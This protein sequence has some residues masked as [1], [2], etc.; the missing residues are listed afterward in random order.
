MGHV[1]EVQLILKEVLRVKEEMH[2]FYQLNRTS[3]FEVAMKS[4]FQVTVDPG[5]YT[6]FPSNWGKSGVN[7]KVAQVDLAFPRL[8]RIVRDRNQHGAERSSLPPN[9]GSERFSRCTQ[10]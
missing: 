2:K 5:V 4:A 1:A 9:I 3:D 10:M 7:V 8:Q 6:G